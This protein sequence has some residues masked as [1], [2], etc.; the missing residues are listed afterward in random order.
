MLVQELKTLREGILPLEL[1]PLRAAVRGDAVPE[2]FPHELVYKCLI[3][4]IRYHDGFAIELRDTLRQLLKAHPTLFMRY[5]IGR[6]CAAGGY[7][8][9]YKE[10]DLLPDV[11]MA[12][13]ARDSLPASQDDYCDKVI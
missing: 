1:E 13:E 4:G 12:E 8:E 3:A 2:E 10:L 7:E 6:A 11:A 9:L 5:K